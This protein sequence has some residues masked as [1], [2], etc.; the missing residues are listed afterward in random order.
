MRSHVLAR[1]FLVATLFLLCDS[2]LR[3][4]AQPSARVTLRSL[5]AEMVD[6]DSVARWPEPAFTTREA[7]SYDRARK[8][9]DQPG[10]FANN[11]HSNFLR[12]EEHG[13]RRE[14]V[15]MDAEGPGAIVRFFLTNGGPLECPIRIYLDGAAEPA[16]V[17]SRSD[18]QSSDLK[19]MPP[20][21]AP[22]PAPIGHGGSTLYFPIPYARHC[23]VTLEDGQPG[24]RYYHLEYCTYA[25]GTTVE[26]FTHG[27]LEGAQEEIARVNRLLLAPPSSTREAVS[28]KRE[29][30]PGEECA[31]TLP[32]GPAAV[33]QLEL[34][35]GADLTPAAR[36]QALRSVILRGS[37]DDEAEAIWCPVGDF[38]GS[39][40]GGR[41]LSSWYRTVDGEGNSVCRWTMPY[42]RRGRLTLQNVGEQEVRVK[43]TVGTGPWSWDARSLYFHCNW[44]QETQI[45]ARP[46][47]DWNFVSVQ[48][49]GVLVG[50]VMSVYNPLASWYG[51]GDE[52]IWVDGEAFPSHLGTGTEDYYNA[53]WAPNPVFQSPFANQPR[54]DEPLSQGNNVYTRSRNLDTIPFQRSLQFDFEIMTWKDSRV[55]Y[56][57][58][59]Y[60][61]GAPGARANRMPQPEEARRPLGVLPP[62]L[63]IPGSV[64]AEALP[65]V[66][67]TPELEI[68]VQDMRVFRG[69]WSNN[70]HLLF[71]GKKVGDF[72]EVEIPVKGTAPRR[73][74]VYATKANDYGLLK[75][76]VNGREAVTRFDG[77]APD[78]SPS[79]PI[80]LGIFTPRDGKLVLRA[81][82][83]GTNPRTVGLRYLA[84][85]D[86]VVVSE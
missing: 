46:E 75:F 79:E 36:E 84:A 57:A 16:I 82:L 66:G 11:D 77:F 24:A 64:E 23:K 10:W 55:D 50:D 15:M 37:F 49:R 53:S 44:R 26:T 18:L 33:R 86:A 70:A 69:T 81:E 74:T 28:L 8:G 65:V 3:S 5:L 19:V 7:S 1:L 35:V 51:E 54:I 80:P 85:L 61:Y 68:R 47:R 63:V 39:G 56:A 43:L 34:S 42:Q 72:V 22:H 20:L 6:P 73:V 52:K 38:A 30:R 76:A 59:T 29:L 31:V 78:V 32:A 2:A 9:P 41:V 13:S 14:R 60:W 67:H 27:A 71:V 40:A 21:V 25:P 58:T 62:S 83:A 17:F 48:G 4:S 12:V 45:P